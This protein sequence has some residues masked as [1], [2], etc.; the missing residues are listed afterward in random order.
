MLSMPSNL[1]T[2]LLDS[3][4]TAAVGALRQSHLAS[5]LDAQ[6]EL[7]V[8]APN[9]A[10]FEVIGSLIADMTAADLKSVLGYHV[11]EGKVLYSGMMTGKQATMQGG[12][13][14][15]RNEDGDIW[16]NG[17]RVVGANLLMANGVVHVIDG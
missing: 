1:T 5:T 7:T 2:T 17:A 13:V 11:I 16:V 14:T 4:L 15:F 9:N 8:F 10:A 6:P 3:N 12:K